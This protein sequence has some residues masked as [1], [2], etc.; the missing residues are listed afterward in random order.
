MTQ[1]EELG[2]QLD[3]NT[4]PQLY[5]P[6]EFHHGVGEVGL[7]AAARILACQL[8][9][10]HNRVSESDSA[11]PRLRSAQT[12]ITKGERLPFAR[13]GRCLGALEAD[14]AARKLHKLN[15]HER[16]LVVALGLEETQKGLVEWLPVMSAMGVEALL[17]RA[18]LEERVVD[19]AG[20]TSVALGLEKVCKSKAEQAIAGKKLRAL[21]EQLPRM[22]HPARLH[23]LLALSMLR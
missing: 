3:K 15:V 13:L 1:G 11:G 7:V 18:N 22:L 8:E 4:S 23:L 5:S 9:H 17:F 19:V 14:R 10:L 21:L 16:H 2:I 20:S 12:H 6:A